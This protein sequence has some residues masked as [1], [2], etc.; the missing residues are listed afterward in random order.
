MLM[1]PTTARP[2]EDLTHYAAVRLFVERARNVRPDFQLT[3]ADATAV[4]AICARLDG[5]PLAIELAAARCRL[6]A[7]EALLAL[8]D[9][10]L[11]LLSDGPR[12]LPARQQTLRAEIGWSYDLLAPADQHLFRQ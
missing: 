12:D 3:E 11:A 7:P 6:F 8:L 4:V 2:W 9:R 1:A 10:R 5:L